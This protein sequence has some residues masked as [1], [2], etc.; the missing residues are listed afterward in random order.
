M[1]HPVTVLV[2]FTDVSFPVFKG[3]L[4]DWFEGKQDTD[5]E[6]AA[7]EE[8]RRLERKYQEIRNGR[9]NGYT[10][11]TTAPQHRL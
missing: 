2:T 8:L 4:V 10:N 7:I 9:K 1:T 3:P 5:T 11:G 6:M